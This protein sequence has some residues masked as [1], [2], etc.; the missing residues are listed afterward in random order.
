MAER[1]RQKIL[2][3]AV[4]EFGAKGYSGART[5]ASRPEPVSI[6]N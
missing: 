1:T 2:D 4:V 5:A 6:S 3:A